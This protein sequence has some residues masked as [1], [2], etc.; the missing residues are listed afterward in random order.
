M[1]KVT[2][3]VRHIRN[4]Y[5]CNLNEYLGLKVYVHKKENPIVNACYILKKI[6]QLE[7]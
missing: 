4:N 7:K 5:L 6:H 3:L 1:L 2:N